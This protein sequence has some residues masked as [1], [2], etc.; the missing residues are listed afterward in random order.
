MELQK[1]W[2]VVV[3]DPLDIPAESRRVLRENGCEL[4]LGRR[5][6]EHEDCAY[7][8]DELIGLCRDADAAIV[9]SRDLFTRR[10]MESARRLHALCKIG[11]GV[12][13]IDVRAATEV[14]IVVTHTPV[15]EH[16][17]C[18]AEGT[19]A[20]MLALLKR[21]KH[22][23]RL[24]REGGWR[25]LLET[26]M[27]Q[28]KTVGLVGLGRI[29]AAVAQRLQ[30]WGVNVLAYDPYVSQDQVSGLARLVGMEELLRSADLVS[31]HVVLTPETREL[32][33]E[34]ELKLMKPGAYL[35]NTA[36]GAV[37]QENALAK[38]MKEGRIAGA[39][40]DVFEKEPPGLDNP[41][42]HME[43]VI[44]TPHGIGRAPEVVKSIV[45]AATEDCLRALRGEDPVYVKDPSV[46]P[47]WR[48][49]IAKL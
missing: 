20:L 44:A 21:I 3:A 40:L 26:V 7:T 41:L 29:G 39:A 8:E 33:G 43:E 37:I 4:V 1:R 19:I 38:A 34:R 12:E 15:P 31:V 6:A 24:T 28:G 35:V 14:G 49:R 30:H 9:S 23:D 32:I 25:D 5:T 47:R 46:L 11:I 17:A 36:R 10:F 2:R 22:A 45:R 18:M 27:L 16:V 42:L 13:G 48:E